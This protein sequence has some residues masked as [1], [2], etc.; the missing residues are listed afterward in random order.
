MPCFKTPK[1]LLDLSSKAFSEL[2]FATTTTVSS[3]D[4]EINT[5]VNKYLCTL[6]STVLYE[7]MANCHEKYV[8]ICQTST[9]LGD[10]AFNIIQNGLYDISETQDNTSENLPS[11]KTLYETIITPSV[12]RL[13][14]T[15]LINLGTLTPL[16]FEYFH[17]ILDEILV[18]VPYLRSLNIKCQH[19]RT[20]LPSFASRHLRL[21]GENCPHLQFLDIS[22]HNNLR[23]EDLSYLLP[24]QDKKGIQ[25]FH[26][27]CVELETIYVFDCGF[28]YRTI[29]QFVLQLKNLKNIGYKEM[30]KVLKRLY[31]DGNRDILNFTHINNM[32]SKVRKNTIPSLRCKR[33]MIDAIAQICPKVTHMKVRIQDTD[34]EYLTSLKH[35]QSV[36]FV[37][38]CGRALTPALGFAAFIQDRGTYLTS[39]A[40]ICATISMT[41]INLL[42]KHCPHLESMWLRSNYFQVSKGCRESLPEDMP[43]NHCYFQNLKI[44]FFRVGDSELA[45]SFV[46]PYVFRYIVRNAKGLKELIVALRAN[47]IKDEYIRGLFVEN[48]LIHLEKIQ[49]CVPGLNNLSGV[50]SLTM[51]SVF[52]I[53]DFCRNLKTL[54][55][56]L[57]WNVKNDPQFIALRER[58]E[59]ENYD[60]NIICRTTNFH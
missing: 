45:L 15:N 23:N 35:L 31:S 13:D 39:V 48:Q 43:M 53:L 29:K 1:T 28:S 30:G 22:F 19:S 16:A 20:C 3:I 14:F 9:P 36:E 54:G 33:N 2:I 5:D 59:F 37:Y 55:N 51:K 7:V 50:L 38:N 12:T 60:L 49:F 6:P 52:F 24:A 11:L 21:I 10:F 41:H 56:L 4:N 18:K 25:P 40:L 46:P 57:S 8:Q 26:R 17:Q 47:V 44:L 27:G 34:V 32:G 58:L 42:G